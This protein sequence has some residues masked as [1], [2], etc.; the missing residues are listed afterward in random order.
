MRTPDRILRSR[1]KTISIEI[2]GDGE[3]LVR[4]P[5]RAPEE[6]I[7]RFVADKQ[8]WIEKKLALTSRS[9]SRAHEITAAAGSRIPFLGQL[10]RVEMHDRKAMQLTEVAQLQEH[11]MSLLGGFEENDH[12][13]LLLPSVKMRTSG[14]QFVEEQIPEN[15]LLLQNQNLLVQWYKKQASAILKARTEYYAAQMGLTVDHVRISSARTNWGSCN[16]NHGINYTW[17]LITLSFYEFDYVVVH[18]LAHIRHRDH[19]P[20]FYAEI[21]KVLP[22]YEN[23]IRVMKN[24]QWVLEIFKEMRI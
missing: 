6:E 2:T 19:S 11:A 20:A 12:S 8:D 21:A 13:V 23:R 7:L 14:I 3:F 24:D 16:A 9:L 22:D 15:V 4:A 1:R 18:E 5:L 17:L 10:I